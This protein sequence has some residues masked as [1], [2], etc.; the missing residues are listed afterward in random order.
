MSD[1]K[2]N[3]TVATSVP[4][5]QGLPQV[6]KPNGDLWDALLALVPAGRQHIV[7]KKLLKAQQ[8][9]PVS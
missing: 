3:N 5:P 7:E 4:A 9:N 2:N 6:P 1:E 8:P